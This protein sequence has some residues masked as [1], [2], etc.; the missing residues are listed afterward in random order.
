MSKITRFSLST[1]VFHGRT[2]PEKANIVGYSAIIEACH[3]ALPMP[4][5]IALISEKHKVY[6]TAD[7]KVLTPRHQPEETLY[8]QLVFALK[9]EGVHLLFFKKLFEKLSESEV[10]ELL[11]IES[12]GQ[13]TRK[14]W[15]LYEWLMQEQLPIADM[16]IKNYVPLVDTSLQYA[17][18]DGE[19]SSRHRIINNLPGTVNFCPLIRKTHLL[20]GYIQQDLAQQKD[21]YLKGISKNVLQR[22]SA[23]LLLKDS[24]ASFSIEG[25]SPKSA[26]AARWGQAIRQAGKNDLSHEEFAR[27]QQLVIENSRFIDMGYRKKGGFIGDRD[28]DTFSPIP[29]HISAKHQDI[30]ILMNGLLETKAILLEEKIDAVLAASVIAFGFVFIHPFVDGNGRIHRYLIHHVLAKKQFSQQGIIFPVSAAILDR[31]MNYQ[32]ALESHSAPL[33]D[34]IDWR[35]TTDHN[36]EVLNETIDFYRYFDAT[37]QAEFLYQCVKDTI[38]IIIPREVEYLNKY[39]E[40]KKYIDDSFEMPDDLVALLVRF[41]EQ[42]NGK[43]SKRARTKEFKALNDDEAEEIELNFNLIF[44]NE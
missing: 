33:L 18:E 16:R 13:Y 35:E 36:V 4:H 40:F 26:R 8:H 27:L 43:I 37:V 6:E 22:A 15:F 32:K 17:L 12:T 23:F 41:L 19:K 25:E 30:E 24:K 5:V 38:E 44:D 7:W 39:E 11:S 1:A 2:L 42:N 9:Y 31:I 14:M 29:D 21:N 34:F 20:E 28:K 3:L 10:V